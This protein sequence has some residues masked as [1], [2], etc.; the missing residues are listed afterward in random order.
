VEPQIEEVI[1]LQPRVTERRHAM[2]RLNRVVLM[3]LGC[4]TLVTLVASRATGVADDI[5][6]V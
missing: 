4:I 2:K 3:V 6:L 1:P 5:K